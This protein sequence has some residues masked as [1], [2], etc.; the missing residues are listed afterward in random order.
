MIGDETDR[1]LRG[2]LTAGHAGGRSAHTPAFR[3]KRC[4]P[5]EDEAWDA[6]APG[7][8]LRGGMGGYGIGMAGV[9][10][11]P[12]ALFLGEG[13]QALFIETPSPAADPGVLRDSQ[14]DIRR[15]R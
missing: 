8:I 3:G 10:D 2:C 11:R 7:S 12:D 6:E 9:D 5:P 14:R 1:R 15:R 13:D 4:R